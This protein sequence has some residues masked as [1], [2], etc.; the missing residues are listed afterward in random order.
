MGEGSINIAN[1]CG[2]EDCY[3]EPKGGSGRFLPSSSTQESH[4]R[5]CRTSFAAGLRT[6]MP[7]SL[8]K[9]RTVRRVQDS[10]SV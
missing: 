4:A 3:V 9:M 7:T 8:Q 1:G 2:S 6:S 10:V 5:I